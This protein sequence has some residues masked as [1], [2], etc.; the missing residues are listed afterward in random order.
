MKTTIMKTTSIKTAIVTAM[1][2]V[3]ASCGAVT[4]N[5]AENLAE[6]A[7]ERAIEAETGESVDFNLDASGDSMVMNIETPDGSQE[8]TFGSGEVPDG[9]P[10]PIPDGATVQSVV[11]TG[12]AGA[13]VT[14]SA[15][16]SDFEAIVALYQGYYADFEDVISTSGPE[17][18]SWASEASASFVAIA[19]SG[20]ET[21]ITATAGT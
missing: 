5:V 1:G 16:A 18:A 15:P 21:I 4:E 9:F 20:E 7:V 10:I 8:M 12:E 19:V 6:T 11:T 2:V 13:F 3:L 17:Q 14:A